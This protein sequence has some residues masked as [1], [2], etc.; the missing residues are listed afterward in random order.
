MNNQEIALV[1]GAA[2]GI[3]LAMAAR[4]VHDG[5][6]VM[7][8]DQQQD[9]LRA[10]VARLVGAGLD[11]LASPAD[12]R[13]RA[14]VNAVPS[15]Q[16]RAYMMVSAAGIYQDALCIDLDEADMRGMLEVNAIGTFIPA[17]EAARRMKPGGR[18][19]TISSRGA[20][21]APDSPT[22]RPPSRRWSA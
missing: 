7:A 17:Q 16:A 6:R 21:G 20:L 5:F 10:A 2:Q 22:T 18:I 1:T 12:V 9:P 3:G 14:A 8:M 13:N 19:A 15:S 4:L 11:V